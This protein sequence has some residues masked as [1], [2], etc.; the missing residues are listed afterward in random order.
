MHAHALCRTD[1]HGKPPWRIIEISRLPPPVVQK[2]GTLK[3]HNP[4][5]I[6]FR[7]ERCFRSAEQ[8]V[9]SFNPGFVAQAMADFGIALDGRDK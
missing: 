1:G 9:S 2:K 8:G 6:R 4:I 7:L 5:G 3:H